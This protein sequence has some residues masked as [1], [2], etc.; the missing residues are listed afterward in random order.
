MKIPVTPS[1]IE[2]ATFRIVAQCINQIR[3][4]KPSLCCISQNYIE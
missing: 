2:H 1:G 4:R 3:H